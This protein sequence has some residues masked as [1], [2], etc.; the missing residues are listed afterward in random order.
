MTNVF[1]ASDHRGFSLKN[2]L[3]S[4]LVRM[5]NN[6]SSPIK[7]V[8]LGPSS[9]DPEDDFNDAALKVS[10]E[11]LKEKN[12]PAFGIVICGS[13]AGVCI[14]ANRLKGIRAASALDLDMIK[15]ARNDD[16]INVLCLSANHLNSAK[17]PLETEK[18]YEDIFALVETFLNT[19]FSDEERYV[20]RIKRL[21]EE[22]K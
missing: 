8:D 18:A 14:Q 13:S 15:S 6:F 9:L 20:R 16:D 21:D 10:K 3:F 22:V 5:G 19:P 2:Q 12:G 1:L 17:D 7:P 4:D 11:I